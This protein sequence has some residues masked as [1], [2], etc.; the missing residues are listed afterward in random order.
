MITQNSHDVPAEI[1]RQPRVNYEQLL[2][3]L[4]PTFDWVYSQDLQGYVPQRTAQVEEVTR[5]YAA[6][7]NDVDTMGICIIRNL[8][9]VGQ[10][11]LFSEY[12]YANNHRHVRTDYQDKILRSSMHNVQ[13]YRHCHELLGQLVNR[14]V[15][16]AV[17]PSYVFASA[18]DKGSDLRK[19]IDSRPACTWNISL[20]AGASHPWLVNQWPLF[21]ESHGQRHQVHLAIGD[22]VLYSGTG[23]EHWREH[24]PAELDSVFGLFF[25]FAPYNYTGSLD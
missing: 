10:C 11:N 13:L 9:T 12:F 22:A 25:H 6:L 21:I 7:K 8:F 19:H 18:Y 24:M 17:K 20:M 5:N 16:L 14:L 4:L 3:P 23:A 1:A 15:P 2:A